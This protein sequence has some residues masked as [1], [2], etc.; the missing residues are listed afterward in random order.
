MLLIGFFMIAAALIGAWLL[1]R[2]TLFEN[3][4]YL[5]VVA[6]S[7]WIG[8]VATVS[9]WV[10][11]ESGRQPWVVQGLLRTADATSPVAA[12]TVLASLVMF[13]VVYGIVFTMG[14][15]YINRLIAKGPEGRAVEPPGRGS[16]SR[17]I[18]SA[19]DAGQEAMARRS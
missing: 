5:R 10:V 16:P 18:S 1:W 14:I 11:T 4:W 12:S 13:V 17:P 19:H 3:R 8:F 6:H 2:G 9:G 15:Y 7:W